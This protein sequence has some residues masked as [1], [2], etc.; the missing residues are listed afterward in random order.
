MRPILWAAT[1]VLSLPAP[2]ASAG[3]DVRATLGDPTPNFAG[4]QWYNHPDAT[5]AALE[6]K[7]V[8]MEIWRTW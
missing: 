5:M 6:G 2:W 8:L 7:V 4:K 1:L 3:D